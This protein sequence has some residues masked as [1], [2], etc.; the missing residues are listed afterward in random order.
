MEARV[1]EYFGAKPTTFATYLYFDVV[2]RF[3][4]FVLDPF[5]ICCHTLHWAPPQEQ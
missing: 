4:L 3:S 5:P 2:A 1:A